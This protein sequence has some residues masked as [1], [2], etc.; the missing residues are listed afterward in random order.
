MNSKALEALRQINK[1]GLDNSQ[2]G[3]VEDFETRL[4]MACEPGKSRYYP[5]VWLYVWLT[6]AEAHDF[7]ERCEDPDGRILPA[8]L[9]EMILLYKLES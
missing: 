2:W 3:I 5:G 1:D 4:F 9:N 7:E 6:V 8:R